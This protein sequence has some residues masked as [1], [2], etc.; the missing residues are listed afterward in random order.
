MAQTTRAPDGTFHTEFFT[1]PTAAAN[2][3]AMDHRLAELAQA[4]HT[5]EKRTKIGR[6]T[7][8]PCGSGLKFKK[9]CIARAMP[10]G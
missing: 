9:C 6:N 2:H 7:T 4:G 1:G 8:C 3:A 5:F 10:T